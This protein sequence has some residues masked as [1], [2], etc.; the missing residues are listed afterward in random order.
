MGFNLWNC[1]AAKS[2]NPNI[3]ITGVVASGTRG[4][5]DSFEARLPMDSSSVRTI[6]DG[7][8]VRDVTPKL[9]DIIF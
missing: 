3:R 1:N 9:L 6:A 7:I 2:I 8:A 4:M 5:K